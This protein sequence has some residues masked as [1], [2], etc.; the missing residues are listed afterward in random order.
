M[1]Q[2][3]G[4]EPEWIFHLTKGSTSDRIETLEDLIAAGREVFG[5]ENALLITKGK[6]IVTDEYKKPTEGCGVWVYGYG[7]V[8]KLV[9]DTRGMLQESLEREKKRGRVYMCYKVIP[10]VANENYVSSQ[11]NYQD[12]WHFL[13][14]AESDEQGGKER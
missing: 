8:P 7:D 2:N 10:D 1:Q 12:G 6:E 14:E 11:L 5:M 9:E 3:R 4:E 13:D